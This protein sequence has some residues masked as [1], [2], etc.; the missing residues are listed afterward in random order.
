[1]NIGRAINPQHHDDRERAERRRGRKLSDDAWMRE[2]R[3][4]LA[5]W[6]SGLSAD[7]VASVDEALADAGSDLA[8]L[9]REGFTARKPP[10]WVAGAIYCRISS[11]K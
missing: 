8:A 11:R 2:F 7:V 5:S 6:M 4:D 1:M 10:L 3:S 9:V